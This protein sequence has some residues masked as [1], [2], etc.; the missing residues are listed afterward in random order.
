MRVKRGCHNFKVRDQGWLMDG[1]GLPRSGVGVVVAGFRSLD[2]S[3]ALGMTE[4]A[5][6]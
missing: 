3:A 1:N 6:E 4:A 5:A 2:S